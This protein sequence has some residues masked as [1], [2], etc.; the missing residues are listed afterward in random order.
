MTQL[1]SVVISIALM[2]LFLVISV[3]YVNPSNATG[4]T[5]GN[6]ITAGFEALQDAYRKATSPPLSAFGAVPT[7]PLVDTTAPAVRGT[8]SGDSDGGLVYNFGRYLAGGVAPAAPPGY[9]WSY[10]S[11]GTNNW[12]CLSPAGSGNVTS[13]GIYKGLIRAAMRFGTE[14]NFNITAGGPGSCGAIGTTGAPAG[15]P[16][17]YAATLYVQAW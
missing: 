4:V 14:P 1:L 13:Q 3:N 12:F 2:A 9:V 16:A 6:Q 10:G 8:G 15:F 5:Y 7:A 11:N 17:W